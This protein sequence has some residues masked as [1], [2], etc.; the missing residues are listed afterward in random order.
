MKRLYWQ[1]SGVS[2]SALV[3]TALVAVAAFV[4]VEAFPIQKRQSFYTEKIAAARR[5]RGA[6]ALVK[7]ERIRRGLAIDP[8]TDP[9]Q[10]GLV[11]SPLTAVT[12]NTGYLDAKQASIN[13][14]FAA[15][16]V[17]LLK[18]ARLQKGDTVAIGLSGSFPA[19][20]IAT[21]AAVAV[22]EL[23]PIVV[24]SVAAS[25]WGANEPDFMWPDMEHLL[26]TKHVFGFRSVAASLGGI[27]DRG[28]GMTK[29]GRDQL[30][31]AIERNGL[32]RIDSKSVPD[33]IELRMQI[34]EQEAGA[35]PI[36][37]YVNVGGGSASVG[38]Y[39]GKKQFPPGINT[40][41]PQAETL[42]DSVML[43]FLSRN[44]P[45][46]HVTQ[47]KK[48]A[49]DNGLVEKPVIA[50]RVGEGTVYVKAEYNRYLALAGLLAIAGTLLA[51]LR[52]GLDV[53]LFRARYD[54]APPPEG[55]L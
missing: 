42:M 19:L 33:A 24:T 15:V 10:S 9:S 40:E 44:I 6:M 21:Y 53:R 29:E 54:R 32:R 4:A 3:L 45:V 50:P 17:Q 18:H 16:I 36:K 2:R 35:R 28:F 52:L 13:P 37:A 8:V 20:N 38:T 23:R 43:R 46:I 41:V 47:I 5:A 49:R 27:D 22:L 26:F 11:G 48:L 14:N 31:V 1:P 12:S 25:E 39:V 51:L 34:Y 30:R 55:M 7:E